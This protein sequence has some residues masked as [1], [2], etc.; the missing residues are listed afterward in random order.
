MCVKC[1]CLSVYCGY[2]VV[3]EF[4][5]VCVGG[6]VCGRVGVGVHAANRSVLSHTVDTIVVLQD[7]RKYSQLRSEMLYTLTT[8]EIASANGVAA[9]KHAS[10]AKVDFCLSLSLFLALAPALDLFSS[11]SFSLTLVRV[12]YLFLLSFS[13]SLPLSFSLSLPLSLPPSFPPSLS[14]PPSLPPCLSLPQ[15]LSLSPPISLDLY[16][17]SQVSHLLDLVS[18]NIAHN[19]PQV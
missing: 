17:M 10:G 1:V 18:A 19:G 4:I 6:R 14:L 12:R 2:C 11:L 7:V 3:G 13:L 8:P 9:A 16:I 5:C 15:T